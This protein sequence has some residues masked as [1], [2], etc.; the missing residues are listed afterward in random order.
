MFVYREW[1]RND[2]KKQRF[3]YYKGRFLFG[4]IPVRIRAGDWIPW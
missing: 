2:N 1:I 3:R 4:V